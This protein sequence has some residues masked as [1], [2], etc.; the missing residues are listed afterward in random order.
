[1]FLCIQKIGFMAKKEKEEMDKKIMKHPLIFCIAII[2]MGM[3]IFANPTT[4]TEPVEQQGLVDKARVTFENFMAD[5]QNFGEWF[6]KNLHEAKGLLIIPNLLK[7][8]YIVGGSGGSGVLLVKDAKTG[9]WS[10][11]AFYT[12]GSV[13]FGLQIGGE[14]AEVVM[15]VRTQKAVDKLLTSSF[16]LGGD[17]SISAGPVGGGAKSNVMTDIISYTRSKGA[18]VGVSLEGAVIATRAQWNQAYYGKA[19]T[20][21]E[22]LVENSVSS[23]GSTKLIEAVQ[24][25]FN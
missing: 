16:K 15:M 18:Y 14:A 13:T 19:V 8:G 25:A 20:P 24:R 21:V 23:P 7:G 6:R 4:A 22:I 10:Q 5:E 1:N 2:T 17:A 9:L 3:L 11:P 12:M